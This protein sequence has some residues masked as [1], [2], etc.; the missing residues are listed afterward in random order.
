MPASIGPGRRPPP[1]GPAAGT[2]AP[3]NRSSAGRRSRSGTA[4]AASTSGARAGAGAATGRTATTTAARPAPPCL[5]RPPAPASYDDGGD[6]RRRR[7]NSI[8]GPGHTPPEAVAATMS[9]RGA[10]CGG[11]GRGNRYGWGG[12]VGE[13][14]PR[15]AVGRSGRGRPPPFGRQPARRRGRRCASFFLSEI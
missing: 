12:S 15:S 14:Q 5:R 11:G 8:P 3:W 10:A 13:S 2:H 4:S 1:G 6:G 7:F 9:T